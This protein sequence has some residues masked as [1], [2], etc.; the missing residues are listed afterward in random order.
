MIC[1]ECG[2]YNPD[3]AT[4]C[5]VCAANLKGESAPEKVEA[6]EE[7]QPTKR[8]SRPSWVVPEQTEQLNNHVTDAVEHAEE[9]AEDIPEVKEP[10]RDAAEEVEKTVDVAEETVEEEIPQIWSPVSSRRKVALDPVD[11]D[12]GE[13]EEQEPDDASEEDNETIYNDEEALEDEDNSFEYE[14]TPP[15]RKQQTKQN[16]T[17]FTV[18]LIAIIVVIVAV[19]VVGGILLSIN[20]PSCLGATK[21]YDDGP[22]STDNPIDNPE[23]GDNPQG[24]DTD[25]SAA[26]TQNGDG[27]DA[28][29]AIIQDEKGENNEDLVSITVVVPAKSKLTIHFPNQEDYQYENED[30]KDKQRKV[31][32]PVQIFYKNEP[33]EESTVEFFP[34]ITITSPDGSSY[35]VNCPSFTRTFPKLN[36]TLTAPVPDDDN[37]IMAPESNTVTIQGTIDDPSAEITINGVV[38]P[39]YE[40]GIFIYE[41]KLSDGIGEDDSETVTIVAKNKNCVSDTKEISIHAYKFVPEPMKLEVTTPASNLR[42][43]K[44]GKLTI[45]G[46]TLPGAT[47]S[48]VSDNTTNVLCG[49]VNVDNEGNFSFQITMDAAF[50]G[51]STITLDAQKEGA[52]NG[53]TKFTVTKGFADKDAFIKFYGKTKTYLEVNPKP[54]KTNQITIT[55]MLANPAQYASNGYG[56]RITAKVVEI[57]EVE[58]DTIIKMTVHKTGE[59]VYVHNLSEKWAPADNIGKYYNVYGNYVGTYSDTEC[60]EFLGWFAEGKS[61][62]KD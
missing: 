47:L 20:K 54:S 60:I 57:S 23:D 31:K 27:P 9:V 46:T 24:G 14:P 43:D 22:S 11:E 35:K 36:I 12:D 7:E 37:I 3:H 1:K 16:N 53:S 44:T 45:T 33:L 26:P 62:I 58:G 40:G 28:H 38:A 17:M 4:Y 50:Y 49:S 6:P 42:A 61:N 52:E 5:K 41:Y 56:Y 10:V 59:T 21:S 2:A 19:L 48:A 29:T 13:D 8:F 18:L 30:D 15:K 34:E 51:M 39:K 32:I 25:P 55:D